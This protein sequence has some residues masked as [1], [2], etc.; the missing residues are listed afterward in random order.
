[1]KANKLIAVAALIGV[2]AV[3][4]SSQAKSHYF[5]IFDNFLRVP[6]Y[7]YPLPSGWTG[8]GWIKWEIPFKL[9]PNVEST[10]L[11]NP[12]ERRIVQMSS[13]INR[14]SFVLEQTG[15]IY[16]DANAMAAHLARQVNSSIVVPGLANFRPKYGRFSDDIPPQTRQIINMAFSISR[17]AQFKK[18]FKVECFFDCDYNGARCE[19][20]YEF[21]CAFSA[22]QVRPNVPAIATVMDFDRFLTVAPPGELAETKRVGGRLLAGAYVNRMWRYAADRMML[23]ILKGQM[24]GM[25]EGM[26][27]MRQARVENERTMDEVRRKWSEMIREVKTVDNPLSPGDKIERP[28]YFN[29]SL[30]N[31]RQDTLIMSDR[32][33]EPHEAEKLMGQGFW[34]VVD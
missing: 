19:A 31:S 28:I 22:A 18:A 30:I 20:L 8:M 2:A 1:M 12:S 21:V 23:A 10:I 9:N 29:H 6:A 17:T 4:M 24:I 14:G 25:N 15:N 34:T 26:D 13:S 32:T 5:V 7:C 33:I 27:L 3:P 11:I 16:S